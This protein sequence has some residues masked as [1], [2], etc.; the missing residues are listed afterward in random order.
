VPADI[1]EE[2]D[3]ALKK[4]AED[5]EDNLDLANRLWQAGKGRCGSAA[6]EALSLALNR[7]AP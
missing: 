1:I 2:T 6:P 3:K 7:L 5:L 4:R